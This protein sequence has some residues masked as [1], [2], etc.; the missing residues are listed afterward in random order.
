M[1]KPNEHVL[2]VVCCQVVPIPQ[3]IKKDNSQPI[4][5]VVEDYAARWTKHD[6]V[7]GNPKP[8]LPDHS[9]QSMSTAKKYRGLHLYM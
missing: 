8:E 1:R 4:V 7:I 9:L 2:E 5:N 6:E 3:N